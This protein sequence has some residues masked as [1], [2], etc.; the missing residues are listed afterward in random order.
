MSNTVSILNGLEL[1]YPDNPVISQLKRTLH[2]Y[3]ESEIG[4]ADAYSIG[5]IKSKMWLI[6]HLPDNLGLVFICAGW[7]GTLASFM[8][9]KVRHKFDKIRS[10]DIDPACYKVADTINKPWVIDG[11][12]FKASTLD[13]QTMQYPTEHTAYRTNGTMQ[14]LIE[15][16]NTII[17]TSCEHID[18]FDAWYSNIPKGKIVVL[19][20]NN[21]FEVN[22]H[23][24]C[25]E[26]LEEFN[27]QTPMHTVFYSGELTLEK[28]TRYMR[29]G[30]K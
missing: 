30:I 20:T 13:I 19:Q 25:S 21:F 2:S 6:E 24:N 10:F 29:I 22:E 27:K 11:W 28:Y 9:D 7:Y 18:N 8:F 4:L 17:N 16:P 1:L 26:S 3:P 23:I 5:Q 15:D 14:T 12:Q